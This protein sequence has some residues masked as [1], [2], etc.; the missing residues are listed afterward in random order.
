MNEP[1]HTWTFNLGNAKYVIESIDNIGHKTAQK[2]AEIEYRQNPN[3][4]GTSTIQTTQKD[5]DE[6]IR[7]ASEQIREQYEY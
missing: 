5:A 1:K 4:I 2:I 7:Q 6:Y 3:Y